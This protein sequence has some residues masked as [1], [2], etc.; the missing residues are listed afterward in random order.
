MILGCL[1]NGVVGAWTAI[2][3]GETERVGTNFVLGSTA[4]ERAVQ[5]P[6]YLCK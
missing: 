6:S 4:R 1:D 5:P 3:C 2:V